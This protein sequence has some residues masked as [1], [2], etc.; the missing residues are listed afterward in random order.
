MRRW[1]VVVGA[2]LVMIV[3]VV[4]LAALPVATRVVG[5]ALGRCLTF[6]ELEVR[7]IDR[8]VL[9]HLVLG[10]AR[11]VDLE[12]T[13]LRFDELRVER[14]RLELP[15]V[16]LPWAL[17]APPEAEA[18][19]ELELTETDLQDFLAEQARFG[20]RPVVELM[21]GIVAIGVE[22]VP[23][24]VRLEVVVRDGVLDLSPVAEVPA[25]LARQFARSGL[26]LSLEIPDGVG[27]ERLDVRQDRV[28]AVLRVD[29]VPGIDGSSGCT[30]PLGDDGQ[31]QE[32]AH[33]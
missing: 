18:R 8:P 26:D 7:S 21:P 10:R 16:A 30:G 32:R 6:D 11:E 28:S 12:V 14:A 3:V 5:G 4:E 2:L 17:R 1:T 9:P 31:D 23:A 24:Q 29:V 25:W 13:G 19:L 22:P 20:L 33:G 27:L 15:E